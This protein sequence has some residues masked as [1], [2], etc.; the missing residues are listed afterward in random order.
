MDTVACDL[1]GAT[2]DVPLFFKS[3]EDCEYRIAQCSVCGLVY[4]NPRTFAAEHDGYF[5]GPYLDTI[6]VNGKL[7]DT[8][9]RLYSEIMANLESYLYPGRLLDVGCAMGHFMDYARGRG[10]EVTGVEC[11]RYAAAWG[12]EH[13]GLRIHPI[14][15][16]T[17]AKFPSEYCDAAA[18]VEVIEHLPS[19]RQ[20]LSEVLRVLRPGGAICLTTP[21]FSSYRSLLLRDRWEVVIPSGH[22]YY[23]TAQTL[24]ALLRSVG[25]CDVTELTKPASFED[26]LAY[27]VKCGGPHLN[28]TPLEEI[29][30][31]LETA[32]AGK[33][34]NGR[35]EGLVY[36]ARKPPGRGV[37][38][39]CRKATS[40]AEM[41]GRIVQA[42]KQAGADSRIFFIEHG[43]RHWVTNTD[44]IISRG[45]RLPD[46]LIIVGPHD[47]SSLPEGPA[48][49]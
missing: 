37:Q 49:E 36:C 15:E 24:G 48:I 34:S 28:G 4:V 9:E 3:E 22:L 8:I 31:Q 42:R 20:A 40:L 39:S 1:C 26:A 16:L 7:R 14:C 29:Q 5:R 33:P 25:F 11:S 35:S 41:E 45:Q 44:W 46:D 6:E 32:D 47:L 27:A 30:A 38:A 43:V 23:F 21:N 19:P 10:W 12:R 17:K 2:Q 18:M 13:F